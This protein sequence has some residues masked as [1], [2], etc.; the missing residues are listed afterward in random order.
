MRSSDGPDTHKA[1]LHHIQNIRVFL[2]YRSKLVQMTCN[3]HQIRILIWLLREKEKS[4]SCMHPLFFLPPSPPPLS[5]P[6]S[7][8]FPSLSLSVRLSLSLPRAFPF[9]FPF[10]PSQIRAY[11][12]LAAPLT[13]FWSVYAKRRTILMPTRETPSKHHNLRCAQRSVFFLDF[14][15]FQIP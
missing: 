15:Q 14:V 5:S 3:V 6:S 10:F 12:E 9:P 2:K 7:S 4:K 1:N 8:P 13:T 11:A